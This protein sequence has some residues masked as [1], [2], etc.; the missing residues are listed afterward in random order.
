[1]GADI[2]ITRRDRFIRAGGAFVPGTS[3]HAPVEGLGPVSGEAVVSRQRWSAFHKT[4]LEA[5]LQAQEVELVVLA[6][7]ETLSSI[8]C[9]AYDA[10]ALDLEV[11]VASDATMAGDA[12]AHKANLRDM[13]TV[14][15]EVSST[16]HIVWALPKRLGRR[17]R[18]RR[19]EAKTRQT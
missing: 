5:V 11:V 9:S 7:V 12:E 8:R 16:D 15:I 13:E 3:G 2:E 4:D 1:D 10:L 17:L 18:P 14:G 19:D 6:G